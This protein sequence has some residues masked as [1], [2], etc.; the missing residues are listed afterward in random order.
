MVLKGERIMIPEPMRKETLQKI[1]AGH[2]GVNKCQLRAKSC[3]YWPGINK[4]IEQLVNKCEVCQNNQRSQTSEPLQSHDIPQRPWETVGTDLFHFDGAEYLII[5]DYYSKFP[6][7]RKINGH[8][9]SAA[10]VK[11]TKQIFSEQGIPAKVV[12]DNGP[13]YSSED[14][15]KFA[16]EWEFN[17]V[18]SS[19]RYPQSNGFIERTIQTVKATLKKA[20]QSNIDADMALLCI[21]TTPV[22][23]VIPSPAELLNGRKLPIKIR[24]NA[25]NKE[26]VRERLSERQESQKRYHDTPGVRDLVPLSVEQH[27]T[28][29]NKDTGTWSPAVVKEVCA[30]PRSYLVETPNGNKLR[31]N[32]SHLR[33]IQP[34]HV[35][36]ADPLEESS[37]S[38]APER[39][40][41][42]SPDGDKTRSGRSVIPPKRLIETY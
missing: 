7:I 1:H 14:Y 34:R 30:E 20:K 12:S 21:R 39:K 19:P 36:F 32:Q 11:L 5:A 31:R 23:S 8:S 42:E 27:V 26:E 9:T 29:Q 3:V 24:N 28:V 35:T 22:D 4:E 10:I 6:I 13:Q 40:Q 15:R 17:H 18:T 41:S 2:Q 37:D 38:P 16:S 33:D 25:H